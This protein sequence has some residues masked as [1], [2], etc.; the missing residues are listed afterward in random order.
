M[1][2]LVLA[3]GL[4]LA[5]PGVRAVWAWP[6]IWFVPG[7]FFTRRVLGVRSGVLLVTLSLVSSIAFGTL[8]C[9]PLTIVSGGPRAWI[10][11]VSVAAF[12]IACSLVRSKRASTLPS[13]PWP[14]IPSLGLVVVFLVH[15]IAVAVHDAGQIPTTPDGWYLTGVVRELAT[16]FPPSNPIAAE[17]LLKQP[18]GYWML[19]AL[20]HVV[21]RLSISVTLH[22]ASAILAIAF[23]LALHVLVTSVAGKRA[24]GGFAI[25][26]AVG[27]SELLWLEEL[28]RPTTV[29]LSWETQGITSFAANLTDAFYDV[30][31]LILAVVVVYLLSVRK[32]AL[33][34]LFAAITPF[35]HPVHAS[36]LFGSV[37]LGSSVA[38]VQRQLTR[39][40]AWL[41]VAPVPFVVLFEQLYAHGMPAHLPF[42]PRVAEVGT[43]GLE[44]L[45]L[46]GLFIPLAIVGTL[47]RGLREC[48]WL[49]A[50]FVTTLLLCLFT[51][52][53]NYHWSFDLLSVASIALGA[54][55]LSE[56]AE[57]GLVGR[58]FAGAIVLVA[59]IAADYPAR[60]AT[61]SD[62]RTADERAA[63]QW[64]R[65]HTDPRAV[66]AVD[67]ESMPAVA[68]ALGIGERRLL[69]GPTY[70]LVNTAT[71]TEVD[72]LARTNLAA[73]ADPCEATKN[74]VDY[75]LRERR[76]RRPSTWRE[77]VYEN[78]T[79][80]I[81]ASTRACERA[82]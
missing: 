56:L 10:V 39:S 44:T 2:A 47:R 61:A 54:I 49:V 82:R 17:T 34:T 67:H 45:R 51:F 58:G 20:T 1:E 5:V 65:E 79:I 46:A 62:R 32:P 57:R 75:V 26:L 21:S 74:N 33:A 4:L 15:R 41:L 52:V 38:L 19:Y 36:V 12:G 25:G 53:A 16:R 6:W 66:V 24:A 27:A 13:V 37:A 29:R 42:V 35:F 48:T 30:P 60:L 23:I 18:W 71:L 59:I 73:V 77:P 68:T 7:W 55:A 8:V 9:L 28:V 31:V 80:A 63:G 50:L 11:G 70:Q 64:L 81:Y 22:I 72:A 14:P 76:S 69:L 43:F 40:H 3:S 78:A